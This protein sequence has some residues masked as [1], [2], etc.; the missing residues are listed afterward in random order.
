MLVALILGRI[1]RTGSIAWLIPISANLTLRQ[2][3]LLLFLSGIGTKA[4]FAFVQTMRSNGVQMLA[5]GALITFSTTLLALAV[6][7]KL[8]KIPAD[9]MLGFVAGLQTQPACLAFASNLTKSENTNIAY[10]SIYPA[11]MI[12]KI[13]LAQLLA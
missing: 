9:A 13:I 10:A 4:G 5:A 7:Y 8:L 6:G 1:E 11:A 12:A 3:G 2:I